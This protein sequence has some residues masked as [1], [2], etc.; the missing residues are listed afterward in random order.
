MNE[1]SSLQRYDAEHLDAMSGAGYRDMRL[2][3]NTRPC[4]VEG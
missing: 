2:R 3:G 1:L 4:L